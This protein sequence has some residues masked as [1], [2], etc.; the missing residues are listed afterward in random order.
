MIRL[1]AKHNFKLLFL[2]KQQQNSQ[3]QFAALMSHYRNALGA[4][5]QIWSVLKNNL[6]ETRK[7]DIWESQGSFW[8][9][10][11]KCQDK[12]C[13]IVTGYCTGI[14]GSS[15]TRLVSA[16][17][18]LGNPKGNVWNRFLSCYTFLCLWEG[19]AKGVWQGWL[20]VFL[21]A[22]LGRKPHFHSLSLFQKQLPTPRSATWKLPSCWGL[23]G[24][25]ASGVAPQS[26]WNYW[27]QAAKR[28]S[29][30]I[31]GNCTKPRSYILPQLPQ[32]VWILYL[33]FS[34]NLAAIFCL[35]R[36]K[37]RLYFNSINS[38]HV[39]ISSLQR[40]SA[41]SRLVPLT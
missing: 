21:S 5:N 28:R 6:S 38:L 1:C 4:I 30:E 34:G 12:H 33:N 23:K 14:L 36:T 37:C 41:A 35:I 22:A 10:H 17:T 39:I 13:L 29:R 19:K 40:C 25:C 9:I 31:S 8:G 3:G 32:L 26:K 7:L 20:W 11:W 24:S 2:S 16:L 18:P 15:T 27:E